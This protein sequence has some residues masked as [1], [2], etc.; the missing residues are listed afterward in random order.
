MFKLARS[1]EW[2]MS[3]R[4]Y[5]LSSWW[6]KL[7]LSRET[8]RI[9]WTYF[10]KSGNGEMPGVATVLVACCCARRTS[11]LMP[12]TLECC[13]ATRP[14]KGFQCEYQGLQRLVEND[15]HKN[16]DE[17]KKTNITPWITPGYLRPYPGK[18]QTFN[19]VSLRKQP[20]FVE[21]FSLTPEF[22]AATVPVFFW[23]SC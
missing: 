17:I 2:V 5:L 4:S 12:R 15:C 23:T 6:P 7:D 8:W 18:L 20:F 19:F 21:F 16:T 11:C 9:L 1:R 10:R 14:E 3:Y 13:E 22:G